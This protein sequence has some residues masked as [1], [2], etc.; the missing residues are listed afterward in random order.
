MSALIILP[1]TNIDINNFIE[2]INEDYIYKIN[3]KFEL[4]KVK[5]EL[6]KFKITFQESLVEVLKEMG[7]NEA[8]SLKADFR[9][10]RKQNDLFIDDV[11][12]K[13]YLSVDEEGTEAAAVTIVQMMLASAG[14]MK[15]NYYEMNVNRPFLFILKN[16]KLPKNNDIV[17]ISKIVELS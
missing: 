1:K 16:H 6:P 11:I 9:G 2:N 12:H 7:M 14:P 4:A 13:T 3:D 5:I 15:L 17:F 10:I 8:F